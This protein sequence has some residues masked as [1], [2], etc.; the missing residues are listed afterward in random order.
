[1]VTLGKIIHFINVCW[2]FVYCLFF[3]YE[4]VVS[5]PPHLL[6]LVGTDP[7]GKGRERGR[8]PRTCVPTHLVNS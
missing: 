5:P 7:T 2:G 1:M 4:T 6:E 8:P 3:L